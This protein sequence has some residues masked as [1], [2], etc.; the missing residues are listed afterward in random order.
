MNMTNILHVFFIYRCIEIHWREKI[1]AHLPRAR[2]MF[3]WV[4]P[5]ICS[6]GAPF[7][8]VQKG[9]PRGA[10]GAP[11]GAP[12]WHII[13][14]ILKNVELCREVHPMIKTRQWFRRL[15]TIKYLWEKIWRHHYTFRLGAMRLNVCFAFQISTSLR[16]GPLGAPSRDI[17]K[18]KIF[19]LND[20]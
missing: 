18:Y 13:G 16:G 3:F 9:A 7:Q 1:C 11:L 19:M 6:E 2:F 15:Q 5:K 12:F 8:M 20:Q 14:Y 10:P 17:W 4:V